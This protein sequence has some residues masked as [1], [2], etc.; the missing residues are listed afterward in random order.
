MYKLHP[1]NNCAQMLSLSSSYS[2]IPVSPLP[3]SCAY[4][5]PR[6]Q[7]PSN[8]WCRPLCTHTET[9]DSPLE[10]PDPAMPLPAVWHS[11]DHHCPIHLWSCLG[12]QVIYLPA[13]WAW[14][15]LPITCLLTCPHSLLLL[16]SDP[17]TCRGHGQRKV[18]IRQ[19]L[20]DDQPLLFHTPLFSTLVPSQQ[21]W[22]YLFF[23]FWFLP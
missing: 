6:P 13:N 12:S 2:W 7:P 14:P 9:R 21:A 8:C 22:S 5:T 1:S 20:P 11:M 16:S 4:E 15:S 10:N 23:Q 18:L 19:L 17:H 3:S